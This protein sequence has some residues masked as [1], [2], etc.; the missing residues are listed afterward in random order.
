MAILVA[1]LLA[2]VPP[3]VVRAILDDAIPDGDRAMI[4]WLAAAAVGAAVGDA[5]LC[6]R[7]SAG[8]ARASA[9]G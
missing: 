5:V 4:T 1:A 8:A 3:L 9:R 6:G 7:C 2:L